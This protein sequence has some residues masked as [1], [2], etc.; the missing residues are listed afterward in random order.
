MNTT[1]SPPELS[2]QPFENS[3]SFSVDLRYYFY[4]GGGEF[5]SAITPLYYTS[6]QQITTDTVARVLLEHYRTTVTE[7]NL[8]LHPDAVL[9]VSFKSGGQYRVVK[10]DTLQQ[11]IQIQSDQ[12]REFAFSA[13]VNPRNINKA[14]HDQNNASVQ[15]TQRRSITVD[16][17]KAQNPG[18]LAVE[19]AWSTWAHMYGTGTAEVSVFPAELVRFFSTVAP[20]SNI[21]DDS[22][23]NEVVQFM[24]R[25]LL[26]MDTQLER[27]VHSLRDQLFRE[28]HSYIDVKRKRP[29][30]VALLGPGP[31]RNFDE[32]EG[33]DDPHALNL[34]S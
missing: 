11:W 7:G 34:N 27:V 21:H 24:S 15:A 19:S 14:H 8:P 18:L 31:S 16:E 3:L 22:L 4:K 10:S 33:A 30:S 20:D 6:L 1:D 12:E 26:E 2:R 29:S 28:V 13:K 32:I 17:L 9:Q 25:K 23:S 5:L